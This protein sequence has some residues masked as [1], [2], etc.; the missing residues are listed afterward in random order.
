[1]AY[2]LP[3]IYIAMNEKPLNVKVAFMVKSQAASLLII[4]ALYY[5]FIFYW[6]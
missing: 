2:T 3:V 1:M 4:N 6:K 5:L